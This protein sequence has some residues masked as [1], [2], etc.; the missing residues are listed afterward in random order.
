MNERMN[1]CMNG[2]V[3]EMKMNERKSIKQSS[4]RKREIL[5]SPSFAFCWVVLCWGLSLCFVSLF[6]SLVTSFLDSIPAHLVFALLVCETVNELLQW[7]EFLL[8]Y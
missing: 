4:K 1:V 3:I 2:G 7:C 5:F 6:V 8:V